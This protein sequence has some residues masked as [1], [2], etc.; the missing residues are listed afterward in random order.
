[1]LLLGGPACAVIAGGGGSGDGG[2]AVALRGPSTEA[3]DQLQVREMA[4]L[5][6]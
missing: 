1:M 4:L 5:L 2:A 3:S 6:V